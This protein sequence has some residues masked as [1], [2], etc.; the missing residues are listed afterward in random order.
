MESTPPSGFSNITQKR[1][2][3]CSSNLATFFIDK[4]VIIFI[5]KLE[6]TPFHV[7]MMTAQIKGVQK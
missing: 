5:I 6:D 4:W 1:E 7:A 3:I 2:K